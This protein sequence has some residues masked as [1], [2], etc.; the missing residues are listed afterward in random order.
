M[1]GGCIKCRSLMP[2]TEVCILSP[3]CGYVWTAEA[4]CNHALV[5][6][7]RYYIARANIVGKTNEINL[8]LNIL[9]LHSVHQ[10]FLNVLMK[11]SITLLTKH[12]CCGHLLV[13]CA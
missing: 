13:A 12:N 10:C 5:A 9:L 4:K 11:N 8:S 3:S 1:D 7:S 2:E 6:M